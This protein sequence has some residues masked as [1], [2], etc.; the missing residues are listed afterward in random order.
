MPPAFGA[1]VG[2]SVSLGLIVPDLRTVSPDDADGFTAVDVMLTGPGE[3]RIPV[4]DSQGTTF[5]LDLDARSTRFS[6]ASE[7]N[8]APNARKPVM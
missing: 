7:C 6:L 3:H 2:V 5:V 8:L 1:A 4:D